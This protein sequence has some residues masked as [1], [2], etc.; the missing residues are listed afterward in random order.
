MMRSWE[1]FDGPLSVNAYKYLRV[2]GIPVS[3]DN[4]V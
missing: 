1:N 3:W 4:V 2:R